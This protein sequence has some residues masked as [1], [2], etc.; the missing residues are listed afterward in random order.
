MYI[1][2][3]TALIAFLSVFILFSRPLRAY[4]RRFLTKKTTILY[5]LPNLGQAKPNEQK[6]QGTAVICGGR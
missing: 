4:V 5:D 1:L 3:S 6:A 2:H